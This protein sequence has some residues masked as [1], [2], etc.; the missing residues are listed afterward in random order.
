LTYDCDL[1]IQIQE[2]RLFFPLAYLIITVS[3]SVVFYI[4]GKTPGFVGRTVV[5]WEEMN[6]SIE[7]KTVNNHLEVFEEGI[8]EEESELKN[9]N[10]TS[11]PAKT[12]YQVH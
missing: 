12:G 8:F 6:S 11:S 2:K 9:L 7:L 1:K 5:G 3:S 10:Y 4:A